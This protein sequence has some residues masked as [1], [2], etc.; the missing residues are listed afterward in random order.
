MEGSTDFKKF[1]PIVSRCPQRHCMTYTQGMGNLWIKKR[2]C[3]GLETI[4]RF[5][6]RL[7][8]LYTG[9]FSPK[10]IF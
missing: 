1:A 3:T 8:G 9:G 6:P 2:L 7:W 10:K 5:P 4:H